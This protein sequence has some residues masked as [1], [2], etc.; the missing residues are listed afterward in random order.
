[1]AV[2]RNAISSVRGGGVIAVTVARIDSRSAAYFSSGTAIR[3]SIASR[4]REDSTGTAGW[5][6]ATGC[7]LAFAVNAACTAGANFSVTGT[8]GSDETTS[9][10][11]GKDLSSPY[12]SRHFWGM[13]TWTFAFGSPTTFFPGVASGE[14]IAVNSHVVVPGKYSI[15]FWSSPSFVLTPG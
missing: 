6:G 11:F 3:F 10:A 15:G 13:Q 14:T 7:G 5:A 8:G 12:V 1:A 4:G 9:S 2:A